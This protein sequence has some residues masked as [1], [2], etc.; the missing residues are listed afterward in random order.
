[1]GYIGP[2]K[3]DYSFKLVGH[4]TEL[5]PWRAMKIDVYNG[6]SMHIRYIRLEIRL[7]TQYTHV[8]IAGE[9][10][11]GVLSSFALP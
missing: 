3:Q 9:T 1:M 6:R 8:G 5:E 10:C 11:Y 4:I 2:T 7:L